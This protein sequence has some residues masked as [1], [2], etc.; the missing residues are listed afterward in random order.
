MCILQLSKV[1]IYKFHYDY[2]KNKYGSKS[3]LLFTNTDCLMYEIKIEDVYEDF[4]SNKEMYDFSIYLTKSK[5]F[6]SSNEVVIGK[7]KDETG[8]LAIKKFFGLKPKMY[9][10]LVYKSE[11]KKAKC[12]NQNNVE[13]ISH[14]EYKDVLLN[15]Q[16]I[17]HSMNRI[18]SKDHRIGTYEIN[19]ISL[20]CFDYKI[21]IQNS[22]Y[23][24]LALV[25]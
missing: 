17:K 3:K 19:K 2:I 25:C 16:C 15:N 8:G 14:N 4:S 18:H 6:D 21:Y 10:F 11:H 9:S 23:N 24:G 22:G 12:M 1:L 20:S 5:Y 7:M 13:T